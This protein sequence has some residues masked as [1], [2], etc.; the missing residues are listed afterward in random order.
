MLCFEPVN[1]SVF[2]LRRKTDSDP[3][4]KVEIHVTPI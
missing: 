4:A 1:P 3:F 2:W